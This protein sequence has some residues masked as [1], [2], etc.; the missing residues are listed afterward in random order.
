MIGLCLKYEQTNYGSKLQALAT[1]LIM[2][3]LGLKYQIIHYEKAGIW[4]KIKSLPRFFNATFRQDKIEDFSRKRAIKKHPEIASFLSERRRLFK[5][6]D[7]EFFDK[8]E[9]KGRY[10]KDIKELA[11]RYDSVVS[12]SDQ[13]WSPAG[14]GTNFY[15]L[16][17]VP[18]DVN[19]VSFASSFGVSKIPFYQKNATAKYLKRINYVSCRENRGAEIVKE[20]TGRDV[21]VLM[22]PVF[23]FDKKEWSKIIPLEK[24]YDEEYVFSYFLGGNPEHRELV[25]TFARKHNLKI[26]CMKHLDQYVACD[27]NFGDIAPYSVTPNQYLS[28]LHGAK[29]VFTDS[30]HGC[31]FSI[32]M[33]KEFVVFNRY[34]SNSS[35]SKNSRIE[36]VCSNLGLNSRRFDGNSTL[37][38]IIASPILWDQV[39]AKLSVY[40][41][42]IWDY[43]KMSLI[44]KSK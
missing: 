30:F 18:D 6:Y 25:S 1:I 5:E 43:L 33:Q 17:F 42:R 26:I 36:S 35:S 23:A 14:L 37:D 21:P 12:C 41:N 9:V 22:D 44:N 20:L 19:K 2:D 10:Y 11:K 38:E 31:A 7:A 24:I 16:M 8:Y 3:R 40:K 29:Y 28:I 13:L 4:F 27:E 32:I 39:E 34:S 15:N